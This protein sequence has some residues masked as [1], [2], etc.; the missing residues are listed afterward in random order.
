MSQTHTWGLIAAAFLGTATGVAIA[1]KQVRHALRRR[2]TRNLAT[3]RA[4]YDAWLASP[5]ID[6]SMATDRLKTAI[7]S[8][9]RLGKRRIWV[10]SHGATILLHGVVESEE[11]WRFADRLARAASADGS[12]RNLLQVRRGPNAG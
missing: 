1:P 11:E 9:V 4:R 2:A 12:V 7:T 6:A 5:R 8:D 10:D 3:L